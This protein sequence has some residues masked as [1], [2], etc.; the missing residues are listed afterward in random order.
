MVSPFPGMNPY[1]EEPTLWEKFHPQLITCLYQILLPG[2]VDRYGAHTEYRHYTLE[3]SLAP[4]AAQK[5]RQE[6]YIKIHGRSERRLVTLIDVVSPANKTTE[7]GRR[8]FL[9]TRQEAKAVGASVVEID[10]VL[11]GRPML[12]Y[13]HEGLPEWD[14]AV[15][16][17]RAT[18]L[19]RFE[20]YTA[21]LQKRLPRFRLP[22]AAN[23]RDTVVDLTA[24]FARLFQQGEFG[25]QIDYQRD[26]PAMLK[27]EDQQWLNDLL[28]SGGLRRTSPAAS[29]LAGKEHSFSHE[30][31]STLAYYFWEFE[32]R[33]HGH[34]R[35]HWY[36]AIEQLQ[37]EASSQWNAPKNADRR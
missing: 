9:E 34:D 10:L 18:Q 27:P 12:E 23:D 3:D 32:G 36:K 28:V 13:S 16:V 4:P 7:T 8:A 25:S 26:P 15:T 29:G 5:A 20:I 6:G 11:Q 37:R 31:I 35:E 21:T 24:A 2:L 1:L 22:L 19:D 17:T 30:A 33:T 14:Y